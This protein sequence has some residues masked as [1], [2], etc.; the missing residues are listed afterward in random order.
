MIKH[1]FILTW[2]KRK[3]H[4]FLIIELFFF[5]LAISFL[6]FIS[7][8]SKLASGPKN[9]NIDNVVD[10]QIPYQAD[11]TIKLLRESVMQMTEVSGASFSNTGPSIGYFDAVDVIWNGKNIEIYRSFSDEYLKDLVSLK[12]REGKWFD[13]T[14]INASKKLIVINGILQ[15]K[16]FPNGNAVGKT[17]TTSLDK[18]LIIGV[19]EDLNDDAGKSTTVNG[20]FYEFSPKVSYAHL[21]VK[22]KVPLNEKIYKQ[23][24]RKQKEY[25]GSYE[26]SEII[27]IAQY[28]ES[29]EKQNS[30]FFSFILLIS[31]FLIVNIVLGLYSILYQTINRRKSEIGIRRAA[32]ATSGAIYKQ[33]IFEVLCLTTFALIFGVA[34]GYQFL[35]FNTLQGEPADYVISMVVAALFIYLL[36]TLCALYPA[37]LAAKI[38]PADA[39]HD[40]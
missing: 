26:Y 6:V 8:S 2:N 40:E 18:Y 22:L 16:F 19:I 30:S 27:S 13:N 9:F 14:S 24:Q 10:I 7:I 34:V 23:L 20:S 17:L 15:E 32:G 11:S 1:I 33:I 28:R 3:Q 29:R 21:L 31:S 39:L 5:F 37:Y 35:L 4:I 36:V 25:G 38:H 12:L